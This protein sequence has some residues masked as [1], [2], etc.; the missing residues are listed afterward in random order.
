MSEIIWYLCFSGRLTSLHIIPSRPKHV[1]ANGKI[2]YTSNFAKFLIIES[3]DPLK[4][5]AR[6]QPGQTVRNFKVPAQMAKVYFFRT[7]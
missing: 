4:F 1:V 2:H 7:F 5:C 6:F 3:L